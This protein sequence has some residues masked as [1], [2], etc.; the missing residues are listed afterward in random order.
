MNFVG[1]SG[2]SK[3]PYMLDQN[4]W[5][6]LPHLHEVPTP[7]CL[8]RVKREIARIYTRPPHGIFIEPEENNVTKM[9][10]L[11]VGPPD[12]PY[13]GGFFHFLV[14]CP[15]NY[16]V[17]PPRV[18]SMTTDAGRVRF[19][20]NI[21]PCGK[22]CLSILGTWPGPSWNVT[23]NIETV[24][25]SIQSLMNENPYFNEVGYDKEK[26]PGDSSRYNAVIQHETIRVAVCD[27]VE[28]CLAGNSECPPALRQRIL[29]AFP[30]YYDR[31]VKLVGDQV[32]LDGTAMMDP[33]GHHRGVYQH[34]RLLERLQRL[35]EQ[36]SGTGPNPEGKEDAAQS[37]VEIP[38][39]RASSDR[40]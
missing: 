18:R 39:P 37:S 33:F 13:E 5:D 21:Y 22:V 12:T 34:R 25:I 2:S 16:P 24:L 38:S 8:A 19:N 40:D 35:N 4:A 10:A 30:V 27:A 20:P 1:I 14:K 31:Y 26:K 7:L 3:L 36:L 23:Q 6:P 15:P 17:S 11:I 9:H 32:H 28:A 29:K